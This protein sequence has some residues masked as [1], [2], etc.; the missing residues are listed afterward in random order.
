MEETEKVNVAR[1][2]SK[3]R[4]VLKMIIGIWVP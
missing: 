3:L 2:G 1:N 4:T